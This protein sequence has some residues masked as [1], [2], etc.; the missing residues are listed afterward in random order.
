MYTS[1]FVYVLRSTSIQFLFFCNIMHKMVVSPIFKVNRENIL[2]LSSVAESSTDLQLHQKHN[3]LTSTERHVA[4][5]S[6]NLERLYS[7]L[8]RHTILE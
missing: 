6:Y 2:I 1:P 3:G 7:E 5:R 4:R 8:Y